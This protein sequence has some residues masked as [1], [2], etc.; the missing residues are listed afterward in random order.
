MT[1]RFGST[2]YR[3]LAIAAL[4]ITGCRADDATAPNGRQLRPN[5]PVA[6]IGNLT[7]APILYGQTSA[8]NELQAFVAD[9][10]PTYLADDFVVPAGQVWTVTAVSLTG[11]LYVGS[12]PLSIRQHVNGLPGLPVTNADHSITPTTSDPNECDCTWWLNGATVTDYLFTW[13]EPLT[14]TAGR[15]WLAAQTGSPG[16]V[17][18]FHWQLR[19]PVVGEFQAAYGM[20]NQPSWGTGTL[21]NNSFVVFGTFVSSQTISFPA[22]TP[23]PAP[24]GSTATLGAT[25]SSELDVSYSSLTPDVCTVSENTVAYITTG[26]CTVAADQPGNG[27]YLP[28]ERATQSVQ[29]GKIAQQIN[30]T[31]SPPAVAYINGSYTPNT[32]GGSSGNPVVITAGPPNVCTVSSGS[33]RLVGVGS[34]TITANQAGNDMYEAATKTQI[35]KVDYRFDGFREPV[36]NGVLNTINAGQ[37]IALKWRLTDAN[38]APIA[39]LATARLKV[40]VLNCASGSTGDQVADQVI[41]GSSLQNLGNGNYQY[42]WK[43]PTAYGNSCKVVALDFGEGSGPR[44]VKFQFT[45]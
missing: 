23:D 9:E 32:T 35:V 25:A 45:K 41:R 4:A 27:T 28:A 24:I 10:V 16:R 33:V 11:G 37:S 43:S 38:G 7:D 30:F 34:C 13:P 20:S 26:T 14:L 19:L 2:R 21:T 1:I 17:R 44:N 12:L 29:V 15:Y 6:D 3:F 8:S 18:L 39:T 40:T 22:I 36:K 5:A 31:S 42:D